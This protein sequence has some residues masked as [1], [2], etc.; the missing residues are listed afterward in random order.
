[1]RVVGHGLRARGIH[2]GHILIENAAAGP[3]SGK[4][5]DEDRQPFGG[6]KLMLILPLSVD[7]EHFH[8][9]FLPKHGL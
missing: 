7:D 5:Y 6:P 1:M 8:A 4:V 9:S 3:R 2:A